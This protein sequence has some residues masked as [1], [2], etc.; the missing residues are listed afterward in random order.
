MRGRAYFSEGEQEQFDH[1]LR[2][3]RKDL[4]DELREDED[5][6]ASGFLEDLGFAES[7]PD[8]PVLYDADGRQELDMI[9]VVSDDAWETLER[10]YLSRTYRQGPRFDA[11]LLEH[12]LRHK[13]GN[14]YESPTGDRFVWNEAAKTID[15]VH[16]TFNTTRK[17]WIGPE[18]H[19]VTVQILI[20]DGLLAGR[21]RNHLFVRSRRLAQK[22]PEAGQQAALALSGRQ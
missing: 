10:E 16:V 13:G 2:E 3:L 4:A 7:N 1:L 21:V 6:E 5:P 22:G 14:V 15:G 17:M 19:P 11:L 8:R 12:L 20:I 18:E 9:V